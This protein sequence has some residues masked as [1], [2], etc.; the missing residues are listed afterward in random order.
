MAESE[1]AR[2]G[3]SGSVFALGAVAPRVDEPESF[4]IAPGAI[5]LGN[6]R[7]LAGAS[8]WF[9]AVIRA[10]NEPMT[11]GEGAN[12][13]DCCVLHSDPG[14]PLSVGAEATIGHRAILHG[15]SIGAGVLIGMGATVMNG[16][17]V[18]ENSVL[19]AGAVVP[20]GASIPPNSLAV[21]LPARVIRELE[22][23]HR[24]AGRDAARRYRELAQ[25]YRRELRPVE[26]LP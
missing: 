20:E 10:D 25:R 26:S 18:G 3:P 5:V 16:A 8:I 22:E 1:A 23:Q 7:V 15:C 21:G 2:P 14:F 24:V 11:I 19:G 9:G 13:Q 6:V 17:V 4:W 12:I